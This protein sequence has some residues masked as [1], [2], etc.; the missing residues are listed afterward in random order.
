MQVQTGCWLASVSPSLPLNQS[1]YVTSLKTRTNWVCKLNVK[2]YFIH[3]RGEIEY[4]LQPAESG[5]Q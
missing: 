5:R 2:I 1:I 3:P 4:R